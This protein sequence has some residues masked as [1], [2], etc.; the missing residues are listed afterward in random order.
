MSR[1][2]HTEQTFEAAIE[3]YLLSK[4]GY[5]MSTPDTF[6]RH[7]ALDAP[8][9]LRFVQESQ[10]REWKKLEAVH[11]A[12]AV[13]K[14]I[15]R[16]CK[17][18]DTNGTLHVLRKG[19]TDHGV[20]FNLAFFKPESGLNPETEELYGKNILSVTRQLKYHPKNEHCLDFC[21]SLNGLPVA[22]I[23]LKN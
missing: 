15:D 16:L 20:K 13:E 9:V 10:P 2:I 22:T 18:L 3:E 6:D 17:E 5:E 21:I 19:I 1:A 8:T 4:C 11:G 23:E 7:R 12:L 14:F